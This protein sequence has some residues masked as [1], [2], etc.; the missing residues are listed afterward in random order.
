MMRNL[1][2]RQKLNLCILS[3]LIFVIV[4]IC[5]ASDEVRFW[6]LFSVV[7]SVILPLGVA[8][9][10]LKKE[11]N[12]SELNP[13]LTDNHNVKIICYRKYGWKFLFIDSELIIVS[14]VLGFDTLGDTFNIIFEAAQGE[15]EEYANVL[16]LLI[17]FIFVE[18]LSIVLLTLFY[19]MDTKQIYYELLAPPIISSKKELTT[20]K[21]TFD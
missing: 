21:L 18:F 10:V 4:V 6:M 9:V 13:V 16:W 15:S 20:S 3:I 7:A 5:N 19:A 12:K 2:K 11:L 17:F 1:I 8:Y 14:I